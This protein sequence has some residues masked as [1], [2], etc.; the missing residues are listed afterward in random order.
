MFVFDIITAMSNNQISHIHNNVENKTTKMR[1]AKPSL[2]EAQ[3]DGKAFLW[4]QYQCL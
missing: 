3:R 2:H 1:V 4:F